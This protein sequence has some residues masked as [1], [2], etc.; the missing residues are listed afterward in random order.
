M[1]IPR[2]APLDAAEFICKRELP[3][4]TGFTLPQLRRW[5]L[6]QARWDW[7]RCHDQWR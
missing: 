6:E 3:A 5:R 1:R 4:L 2:Q 7:K